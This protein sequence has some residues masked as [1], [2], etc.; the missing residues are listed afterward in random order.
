MSNDLNKFVRDLAEIRAMENVAK[1]AKLNQEILKGQE[2]Q[3]K[4]EEE[5]LEIEKKKIKVLEDE[6]REREETERKREKLKDKRIKI[7]KDGVTLDEIFH[8]VFSLLHQDV[9]CNDETLFRVSIL[10]E[11]CN[12]FFA[13][14]EKESVI[15]EDLEDLKFRA[16]VISFFH[17]LSESIH[18]K[19][20][21]SQL[22][23]VSDEFLQV[24]QFSF[25][26]AD[27]TGCP[28]WSTLQDA[29]QFP[30]LRADAANGQIPSLTSEELHDLSQKIDH[31]VSVFDTGPMTFKELIRYNDKIQS[32]LS[33]REIEFYAT[34]SASLPKLLTDTIPWNHKNQEFE[35]DS[36]IENLRIAIKN[37]HAKVDAFIENL[38][39]IN[40]EEFPIQEAESNVKLLTEQPFTKFAKEISN[41]IAVFEKRK[42]FFLSKFK[43]VYVG[44][45]ERIRILLDEINTITPRFHES[46]QMHK[47]LI[48][49]RRSLTELL[50]ERESSFF[51]DN[52]VVAFVIIIICL[53]GVA[54]LINY[55]Q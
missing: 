11:V 12:R 51:S 45:P 42:T 4:L 17:K 7:R 41:A 35:F 14:F 37:E 6:A 29:K 28:A 25:A 2:K 15:F 26:L 55:K 13:D 19:L 44:D 3:I 43:P 27:L 46:S 20:D 23:K 52:A 21:Q 8:I 40:D 38:S 18:Q 49:C 31:L 10:N 39:R 1:N 33:K 36:F 34:V 22:K 53:F 9:N 54:V 48:E 47:E 24:N 50:I 5:R 30:L 16:S 32:S